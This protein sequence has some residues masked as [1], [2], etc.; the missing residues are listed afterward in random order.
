MIALIAGMYLAY[1]GK[2]GLRAVAELCYHK[3]HYAARE[4]DKLADYECSQQGPFFNEFVVE[5][6]GPVAELNR[7]L[8]EDR[9]FGRVRPEA[10]YPDR[11]NQMLVC[12]TE[13]NSTSP[14][15]PPGRAAWQG[16]DRGA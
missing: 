8:L 11:V 2:Q 14:D 1:M 16:S 7:E 3:A 4:I 12:V 15:R 13:M 9:H 6:P 5:C 10:D